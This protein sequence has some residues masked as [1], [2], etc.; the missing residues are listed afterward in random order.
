[1]RFQQGLQQGAARSASSEY[2]ETGGGEMRAGTNVPKGSDRFIHI[3][4]DPCIEC[5]LEAE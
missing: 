3:T 1:M 4:P 2:E 5:I